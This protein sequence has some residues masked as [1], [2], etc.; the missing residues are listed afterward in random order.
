MN[1]SE[2]SQKRVGPSRTGTDRYRLKPG[3]DSPLPLLHK[4]KPDL[5]Q[6]WS[7]T[8]SCLS[9]RVAFIR[10][11]NATQISGRRNVDDE[12][13]EDDGNSWSWW[14]H[15]TGLSKLDHGSKRTGAGSHPSRG[16]DVQS[17]SS[18]SSSQSRFLC[19]FTERSFLSDCAVK[20]PPGQASC[21]VS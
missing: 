8:E 17:R 1:N 4:V 5:F 11:L 2:F 3:P 19:S 18:S 10:L 21:R 9:R 15:Q 14:P 13:D 6:M 20:L 7:R 12:D 16:S